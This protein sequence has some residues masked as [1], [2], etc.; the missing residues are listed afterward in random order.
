[1]YDLKRNV[2]QEVSPRDLF[3]GKFFYAVH[4][5][6]GTRDSDLV[7]DQIANIEQHSAPAIKRLIQELACVADNYTDLIPFVALQYC[8]T[9]GVR[10]NAEQT[11][12][13]VLQA[14][15]ELVER[16]GML[17]ALP[18]ELAQY[19][20]TAME[21]LEQGVLKFSSEMYALLLSLANMTPMP[22]IFNV[23]HWSCLVAQGREHF[24]L[25]DNPCSILAPG[26]ADFTYG[27]GPAHPGAEIVMP[28]HPKVAV[29]LSWVNTP[30]VRYL[31]D[32]YI[33]QI[34]KRSAYF[35][36]RFLAADIFSTKLM[37]RLEMFSEI[38]PSSI[39]DKLASDGGTMVITRGNIPCDKK[40][41]RLYKEFRSL[42]TGRR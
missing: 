13:A 19:G 17:P 8:R 33:T 5:I 41:R 25:A 31:N 16:R 29:C 34:N 9:P 12:T 4:D 28:I 20:T 7:E 38:Q 35:A 39:S 14:D 22:K 23:M 21:L 2:I 18:E 3:V 24:A 30:A 37:R 36:D 40:S 10:R 11:I 27:I 1:M 26:E 32:N 15:F 6:N 42:P